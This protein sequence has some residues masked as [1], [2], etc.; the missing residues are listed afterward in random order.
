M[1]NL[2][3]F[4]SKFE[5]MRV[6]VIGQYLRLLYYMDDYISKDKVEKLCVSHIE[7]LEKLFRNPSKEIMKE[8][9][10]ESL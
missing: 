2:V 6:T 8:A 1:V 4:E 5:E 7:A 9:S 10:K 3:P